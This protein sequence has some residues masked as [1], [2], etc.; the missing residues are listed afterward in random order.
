MKR[1]DY[2]MARVANIGSTG[3]Y[4]E[5]ASAP[6]MGEERIFGGGAPKRISHHKLTHTKK[7]KFSARISAAEK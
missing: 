4:D 5:D 1:G 3:I 7:A 6:A 2:R